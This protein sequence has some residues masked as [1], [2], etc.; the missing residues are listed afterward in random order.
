MTTENSCG[1]ESEHG[2]HATNRSN[3]SV[4]LLPGASASWP[5]SDR[6]T[7]P[8]E[9]ARS[10][11]EAPVAISPDIQCYIDIA[12]GDQLRRAARFG[13]EHA[14][15]FGNTARRLL[16]VIETAADLL[17]AGQPNHA[18]AIL[19]QVEQCSEEAASHA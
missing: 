14:V 15:L 19:Q 3:E 12:D 10:V 11:V 5:A 8:P 18:L 7:S 2:K 16:D 13:V 9:W 17:R 6:S 4:Q 1:D